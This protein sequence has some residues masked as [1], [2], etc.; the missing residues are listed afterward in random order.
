[1]IQKN[2][3]IRYQ[4]YIDK[5]GKLFTEKLNTI[6]E[7]DKDININSVDEIEEL[8]NYKFMKKNYEKRRV[9]KEIGTS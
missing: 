1:M 2:K 5:L 4:Y 3:N 6:L 8:V 9:K 7:N